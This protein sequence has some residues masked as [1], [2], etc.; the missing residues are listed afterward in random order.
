MK[1]S[2]LEFLEET[3]RRVPDK[4][5][6]YDDREKMT[7]AA[8]RDKA[9]RIGTRL[10]GETKPRTPVALLLDSRSIRNICTRAAPTRRWIS[11]CRRKGLSCCW[12]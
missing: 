12:T 7:Y 6:F 9:K 2:M 5:A 4:T 10:I 11:P 1:A 8:L 3:A